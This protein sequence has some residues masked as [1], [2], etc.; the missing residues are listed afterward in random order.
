MADP[1]QHDTDWQQIIR[2]AFFDAWSEN[3]TVDISTYAY[4]IGHHFD[5]DYIS[6]NLETMIERSEDKTRDIKYH[7]AKL[8]V[9][10][11]AFVLALLSVSDDGKMLTGHNIEVAKHMISRN[12]ECIYE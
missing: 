5:L 9:L 12:E 7:S 2:R 8:R 4:K 1:H 6:G 11:S 10:A 3:S